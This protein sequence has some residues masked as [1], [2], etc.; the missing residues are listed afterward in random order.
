V[1][2]AVA[3]AGGGAAARAPAGGSVG[4]VGPGT[5]ST[6]SRRA[7]AAADGCPTP[8][9]KAPTR[10]QAP[11]ISATEPHARLICR[12]TRRNPGVCHA[13]S[14]TAARASC[15][16]N[17]V[18]AAVATMNNP[19]ASDANPRPYTVRNATVPAPKRIPARRSPAVSRPAPP[20]GPW[21]LPRGQRHHGERGDQ[22]RH[23]CPADRDPPGQHGEQDEGTNPRTSVTGFTSHLVG[24][25]PCWPLQRGRQRR[26]RDWSQ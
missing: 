17:G 7:A 13:G 5:G 11:R 21:S 4:S 15:A 26:L 19:N 23:R 24:E 22:A 25:R 9:G 6:P 2:Y 3:G 8:R 18:R 20:A 16:V 12:M 1:A 10:W 14:G